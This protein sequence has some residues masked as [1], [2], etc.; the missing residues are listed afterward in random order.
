MYEIW[1]CQRII[2]QYLSSRVAQQVKYLVLSLQRLGHCCGSGLF[3]GLGTSAK[4][5][6]KKRSDAG[7]DK[8]DVVHI[9]NGIL[10]SH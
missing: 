1:L 9:H 2:L 6:R 4:R 7:V 3:P 5:K 10:L 8:E